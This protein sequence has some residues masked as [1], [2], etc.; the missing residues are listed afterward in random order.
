LSRHALSLAG[1]TL[2]LTAC[3]IFTVTHVN[4]LPESRP[5]DRPA[6]QNPPGPIRLEVHDLEFAERYGTFE[7]VGLYRYDSAGLNVGIGYNDLSADCGIVATFYV[8]PTPRMSFVGAEP[9]AVAATERSWLEAEFANVRAELAQFHPQ[10]T[11]ER[12]GVATTPVAGEPLAGESLTFYE[13]GAFSELRLFV[14]DHQWFLKYRFTY[15]E[16]CREEVAPKIDA[17]VAS[18]PWSAA[19]GE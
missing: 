1:L 7:R 15:P 19:A 6:G 16:W 9:H 18:L 11:S 2:L 10:M 5:L 4:R 17:L 3:P 12:V 14:H 13:T 8:Y